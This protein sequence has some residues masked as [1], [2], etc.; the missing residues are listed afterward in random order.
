MRLSKKS[1]KSCSQVNHD[2]LNLRIEI[3]INMYNNFHKEVFIKRTT[4]FDS[5][6]SRRRI[7][8]M[9][10]NTNKKSPKNVLKKQNVLLFVNVKKIEKKSVAI[11]TIWIWSSLICTFISIWTSRMWSFIFFSLKKFI[12][13]SWYLYFIMDYQ[14]KKNLN[15]KL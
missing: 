10:S 9:A 15:T 4:R 14:S 13:I 8:S 11:L 2:W 12:I 6:I 1:T 7:K 3:E 5:T